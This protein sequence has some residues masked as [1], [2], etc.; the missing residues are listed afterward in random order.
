[1]PEPTHERLQL[2]DD[3]LFEL[4]E[5]DNTMR[6]WERQVIRDVRSILKD[7]MKW[8]KAKA[9]RTITDTDGSLKTNQPS[10]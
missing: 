9:A 4:T 7:R 2:C 10:E 3:I 8:L 5:F 1:M 6:T